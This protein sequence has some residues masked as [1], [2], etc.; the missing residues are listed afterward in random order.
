MPVVEIEQAGGVSAVE[1]LVEGTGP[2]LLLVHGTGATGE[3]NWRPLI[4]AVRDRFTVVAPDLSG[5][6]GTTDEGL[7]LTVETLAGQAEAA[8]A[9]AGL[10]SYHVVGHSLG[11]SVAAAIAG[12]RPEAVRS[13]VLHAGFVRTDPWLAFVA[14]LWERLVRTDPELFARLLQ[15]TAM[16]PASLRARSTEDFEAAAAGFTSMIEPGILRQ[17]RLDADLDISHL[18]GRVIAPTVVIASAHDQ[19]VPTHHQREL[20]ER[21]AGARYVEVDA[22]HGLPFENPK[23]FVDVLLEHLPA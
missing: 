17:I 16:G 4:D 6:G 7:P 18:V 22:G 12:R 15:I 19:I 21:I 5:S 2:G 20:A 9:H 1:Y 13:L 23:L 11:A 3:T 14:D 10:E 8:A